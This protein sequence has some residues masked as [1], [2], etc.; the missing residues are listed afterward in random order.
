MSGKWLLA[1]GLKIENHAYNE[2]LGLQLY[3]NSFLPPE[4]MERSRRYNM[5]GSNLWVFLTQD[6]ITLVSYVRSQHYYSF[7]N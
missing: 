4:A 2:L 6:G 7:G 5:T 3:I 1:F